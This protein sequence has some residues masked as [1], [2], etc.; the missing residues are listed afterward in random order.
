MLR[1]TPDALF[2]WRGWLFS[3][4]PGPIGLS[5]ELSHLLAKLHDYRCEVVYYLLNP[6]T[7]LSVL[8]GELRKASA[9]NASRG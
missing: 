4:A 5:G 7:Q 8:L 9:V 1:A 2:R 6:I 3:W